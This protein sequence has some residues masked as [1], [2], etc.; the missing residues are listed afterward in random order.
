MQM[1][2][3]ELPRRTTGGCLVRYTEPEKTY[4]SASTVEA[5]I[6][7]SAA[8]KIM[9]RTSK[10][11]VNARPCSATLMCAQGFQRLGAAQSPRW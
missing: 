11:R 2:D 10:S 4:R 3:V 7:C 8:A 5:R 9:A 1:I 6:A